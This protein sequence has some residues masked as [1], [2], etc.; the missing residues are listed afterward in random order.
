MKISNHHRRP[1]PAPERAETE[2]PEQAT[3]ER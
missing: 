2:A 1:A 3:T